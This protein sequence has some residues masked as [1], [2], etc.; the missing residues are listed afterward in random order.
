MKRVTEVGHLMLKTIAITELTPG[1]YVEA[2]T[3]QSGNLKIKTQGL[4]KTQAL[5]DKLKK[6]GIL[7]LTIDLSKSVLK[8]VKTT[9]PVTSTTSAPVTDPHARPEPV[10]KELPRAQ[11]LYDEAK[12]LQQ[13]AFDD[14]FAGKTIEVAPFQ[15]VAQGFIDSVFRNQDALT[16]MTR[17]REKDAYLLEHSIN[18]SILMSIFAKHLQLSP[19]VI[20]QL[21]T[22][23]LLH[24]IG[25]IKVR[26]E[27]LNKPGKLSDSEFA[28]MREHVV[29]SRQILEHSGIGGITLEVAALHHE[30][31]DGKGYPFGYQGEQIGQY[32]RMIAIVDA[33][34]AMT[35]DRCYKV[36]M[37]P[38]NAFK[39]LLKDAGSCFDKDLVQRFIQAIGLHPVG[40]LV[41]LTS[42][43]LAIVTEANPL[44]P[45]QPVV[46]TFYHAKFNRYTEIKD[47]NLAKQKEEEIELAV[48]P[49]DYKIDLLKF[50]K[51]A[52]AG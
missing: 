24:D 30:R 29:F 22:G 40:T 9:T 45:L 1:M 19:D 35:A 44:S 20:L 43:R 38:L 49:D 4:V 27:V 33:Y 15:E 51:T 46:K 6:A 50:F 31:L 12:Q 47:I 18:V 41:K 8:D 42:E 39:I 34:D 2:V 17:M 37:P 5:V 25:K 21:A 32:A 23:A 14:I 7:E 28:E 11:K 13:K 52:L 26:D 10:S 3:K 48:K 36:G 16:C